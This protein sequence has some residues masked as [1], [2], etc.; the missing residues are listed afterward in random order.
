MTPD[1]E[2]RIRLIPSRDN[3]MS[4]NSLRYDFEVEGIGIRQARAISEETYQQI[5][6]L[7]DAMAKDLNGVSAPTQRAE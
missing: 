5:R 4:R 1:N 7:V 6:K 3:S 2:I